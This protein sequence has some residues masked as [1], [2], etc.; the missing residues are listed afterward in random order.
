MRQTQT[1]V[2]IALAAAT[3]LATSVHADR[4]Q[5]A[6]DSAVLTSMYGDVQVR[7][8]TG[9]YQPAKLN[10]VLAPSDGVKTG[11]SSRAEI[12]LGEGGY[13]RMAENS[14][15]LITHLDED[16]T[17]SFQAVTGGV[18]VTIER[19]LGGSNK[20]EVRMPSAVAS[21]KG[22]VFRCQVADDGTSET[23][24]YE[25]EVD[26]AAGE[27]H[28]RV[29]PDRRC[30]VADDR[31]VALEQFDLSGDDE[32]A[33]VM[34]NRHRDIIRHLNNPGIIVG[35][36]EHGM[37]QRGA[38]VASKAIAEQLA[39]HGLHGT[40]IA[41][42]DEASFSFN[43]DGTI[44]WERPPR[45]DYCVIGD[46]TLVQVRPLDGMFS[47]RVRGDLRLVHNGDSEALTSI[48][49][50]VPGRGESEA[51]A[52]R[53]ALTALGKRVGAGL[54]PRIIREMMQQKGGTV[55]IDISGGNRTSASG[56][57]KLL[58]GINGVLRTA[59]LALP[60]GRI[61]LAV[62]TQRTPEEIAQFIRNNA[63][64]GLERVAAGERVIYVRF[65]Q[66]NGQTGNRPRPL[67]QHR[68]NDQEDGGPRVKPKSRPQFQWPRMNR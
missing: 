52:V 49:V 10:E 47:A 59:P 51:E 26:V 5:I 6:A 68:K 23:Y 4:G 1:A 45:S 17:T 62:V 37:K 14:Q 65:H 19:V 28:L 3:A 24:V 15:L 48:Q 55:R 42:V 2:L 43:A 21:V 27:E 44:D 32:A 31:Q 63:G 12:S 7:H 11:P 18:W 54:A 9:G 34:Y 16:G 57:R 36:R 20:F 8:G 40:S 35:L 41:D 60:G 58:T 13:V 61:S 56:F 30:R 33:W 67:L 50:L 64:E 53:D 25:G 29:T 46:A 38:F 39:L 66:E 22:T